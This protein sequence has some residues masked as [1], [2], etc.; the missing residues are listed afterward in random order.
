MNG[1][2]KTDLLPGAAVRASSHSRRV[3]LQAECLQCPHR[4]RPQSTGA[5]DET[6]SGN[7]VIVAKKKW[8]QAHGMIF[9]EFLGPK[10]LSRDM[11]D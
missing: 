11:A 8:K 2:R 10:G 3:E 4:A 7:G 9:S 6:G 5:G 1:T